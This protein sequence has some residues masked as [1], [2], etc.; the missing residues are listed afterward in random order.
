MGNK[1]RVYKVLDEMNISYNISSHPPLYTIGELVHFDI[2]NKTE[3]AK[4]L[5]LRNDNGKKHYLITIRQ[6]KRVDL[7]EL[8][9][10]IKSSRLS[11]AS[12]ERLMKHLGL[13]KGSV[14]PLGVINNVESDVE[15][16]FDRDLV[17]AKVIGVHPNENDE[18]IWMSYDDLKQVVEANGNK[19]GTIE[20]I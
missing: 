7:K 6:E 4:N 1:E 8:R 14:T 11:F 3:I 2:P 17:G 10:K 18:T 5:F 20:I 16:F 19:V 12:E 9:K 15:V 13:E